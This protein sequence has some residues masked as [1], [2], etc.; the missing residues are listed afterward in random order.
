LQNGEIS[1]HG[2]RHHNLKNID[3]I[4]PHNEFVV[5]SG[6]SGSGKSTLA[7]DVIFAEGQRRFL[8]SMSPLREAV[9]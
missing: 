4:I 2:L 7:F 9:R 5:I 6:L 8:D 1:I 3:A